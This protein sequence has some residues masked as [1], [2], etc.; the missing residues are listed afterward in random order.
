MDDGLIN[1]GKDNVNAFTIDVNL[2]DKTL[3]EGKIESNPD[4][5][6][7]DLILWANCSMAVNLRYI[8]YF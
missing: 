4:T 2:I 8:Y 1:L 5:N 6:D 7:V 3:V